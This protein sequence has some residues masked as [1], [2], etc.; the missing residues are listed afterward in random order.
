MTLTDFKA[1]LAMTRLS[2]DGRATLGALLVLVDGQKRDDAATEA[3]C[4]ASAVSAV[5]GK[6]SRA[7][8]RCPRCGGKVKSL[9]S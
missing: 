5:I 1:A 4:S 3:G 9:K 7:A 8:K 2:I 6:I